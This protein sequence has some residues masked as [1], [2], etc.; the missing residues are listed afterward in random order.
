[1]IA[2]ATFIP[3][4]WSY[5]HRFRHSAERIHAFQA[6]AL[7]R[8]PVFYRELLEP[9]ILIVVLVLV[10]LVLS[11]EVSVR[12]FGKSLPLLIVGFIGLPLCGILLARITGA[13]LFLRYFVSAVV[14]VALLIGLGVGFSSQRWVRIVLAGAVACALGISCLN[15]VRFYYH[16]WGD[17]VIE[18][19]SKLLLNTIPGNPLGLH[20]LLTAHA[21][22]E[23]PVLIPV[24]LDY[25]YLRYYWLGQTGRLYGIK[26]VDLHEIDLIL[27]SSRAL[28]P[29][30]QKQTFEQ[31]VEAH[32][33]YF[34]YGQTYA[35]PYL[36]LMAAK[37]G[38]VE[39]FM[40]DET[41]DYFLA[42]IRMPAS[43]PSSK[44]R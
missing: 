32:P 8:V 40:F 27:H 28:G 42:R 3:L 9:C 5:T 24:N 13:P 34:I 20:Q 19:S 11:R 7:Y 43:G 15:T 26:G 37:G 14:G 29:A 25:N 2:V 30:E 41:T 33:V 44:Q 22:A 21:T 23:I 10:V 31:F 6:S 39:S 4:L 1:M 38:A 36:S 16:G 18:P 12:A 17:K 35:Y